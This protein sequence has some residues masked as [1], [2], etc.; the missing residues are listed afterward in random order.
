MPRGLV[1]T[2]VAGQSVHRWG[3]FS[4][5]ALWPEGCGRM[6]ALPSSCSPGCILHL[7]RPGRTSRF[8]WPPCN[9]PICRVWLA[10]E[11]CY[12]ALYDCPSLLLFFYLQSCSFSADF[13]SHCCKV[14]SCAAINQFNAYRQPS[15][16]LFEWKHMQNSQQIT[17]PDVR[18]GQ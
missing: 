4:T 16:L 3:R 14:G 10:R 1:S 7:R 13:P 11:M 8:M 18:D 17:K 2:A 12:T 6:M 15:S 5:E 9:R